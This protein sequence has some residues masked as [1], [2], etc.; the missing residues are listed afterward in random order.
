MSDSS[1]SGVNIYINLENITV[2]GMAVYEINDANRM[3]IT[4]TNC[5]FYKPT[6]VISNYPYV[7]SVIHSYNDNATITMND[8]TVEQ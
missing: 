2:Y 4:A 6:T 1:H 5:K 3:Q 7:R 8:C